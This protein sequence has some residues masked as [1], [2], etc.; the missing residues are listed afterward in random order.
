M[1]L[2]NFAIWE[3]RREEEFS[4]LKNSNEAKSENPR[5]CKQDISSLH[6]KWLLNAGASFNENSSKFVKLF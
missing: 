5:S 2:S 6:T 3:V 4:P 1:F